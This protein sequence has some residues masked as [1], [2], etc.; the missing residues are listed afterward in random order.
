NVPIFVILLLIFGLQSGSS[1]LISQFW[2]KGD[3]DSINRVIG[4]GFYV[5]AA[6]TALFAG[7]MFFFPVQFIGL[8]SSNA[9][10]VALAAEYARPV[11]FSYF[12]N[13][14]TE[15]YI[16]AHRS[17]ENPKLG[18][19]ILS[20]SMVSNTFLNWVLIFGNLGAPRLGVSGAAIATLISRILEFVVIAVYA[21]CNRRFRLKPRLVLRP[22]RLL[23]KSYVRYSTPVVLNEAMWGLGTALYPTIMGHMAGST[24]ILA[25]YALSG[26]IEKV[27]TVA[28]FAIASTAAIIVGREIGRGTNHNEV[29]DIGKALNTMAFLG[30]LTVGIL[31][32][33][34]TVFLFS[35]L[36]Y[37]QFGLTLEAQRIATM[38]LI[39]TSSF[40]SVRSFNSTNI[41]GVLRGG[42]DVRA[43]T[44]TDLTPL[45]LFSVPLSAIFGLVLHT[46]I[47]WVYLCISLENVVKFFLGVHRF[48]SHLWIHDVTLVSF[49]KGEVKHENHGSD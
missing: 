39:V 11:G 10:L 31:M 22:G 5:A 19:Y 17:M 25:A 12:F 21:V 26:N 46:D 24:E 18:L 41:V 44:L 34:A 38:M 29:Y 13:A 3:T 1:V 30:G 35:P 32:I 14:L 36:V 48:R 7:V 47:F 37:P 2:G 40:L 20:V 42:G 27:C 4:I 8:F 9:P 6:I 15:V 33:L 23:L 49:Q 43:A 45:W 16:A 28:V